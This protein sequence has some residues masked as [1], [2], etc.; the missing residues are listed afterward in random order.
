MSSRRGASRASETRMFRCQMSHALTVIALSCG[1]ACA[2]NSVRPSLTLTGQW[3]GEH[4]AMTITESATHVEF[5]CAHGDMSN[6]I[7]TDL[8]RR[9]NVAGTL[10][11]EHGGPVQQGEPLDSH[12]ASYDGVVITDTMTLTVQLVD[13]GESMGTFELTRGAAGRLV[14]CL[15][16]A[17]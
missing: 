11:R 5:D 10:V 8:Q 3:G 15:Q 7:K 17:R 6:Q 16:P 12:P 2:G 13:S 14:K 9:F 4:V 1:S